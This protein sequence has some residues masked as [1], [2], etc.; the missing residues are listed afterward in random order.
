M[1][2]TGLSYA[3]FRLCLAC[4]KATTRSVMRRRRRHAE[5]WQSARFCRYLHD[6]DG[7]AAVEGAALRRNDSP[8][9]TFYLSS[10]TTFIDRK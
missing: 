8:D 3:N 6:R 5:I 1:L 10:E 2:S 9:K 7:I 4:S